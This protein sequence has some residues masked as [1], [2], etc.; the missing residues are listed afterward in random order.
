[1]LRQF[2][3]AIPG[4]Y[5]GFAYALQGSGSEYK[6]VVE[7]WNRIWERSGEPARDNGSRCEAARFGLRLI[8]RL[9]KF[10]PGM[11]RLIVMENGDERDQSLSLGNVRAVTGCIYLLAAQLG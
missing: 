4:M 10:S 8:C 7:S 2:W 1:M 6:L 9:V 3:F 5:G 11:S